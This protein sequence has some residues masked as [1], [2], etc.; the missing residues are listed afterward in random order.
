[1]FDKDEQIAANA[2]KVRLGQMNLRETE[3]NPKQTV[4]L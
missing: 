4:I 3:L 2:I 1:M